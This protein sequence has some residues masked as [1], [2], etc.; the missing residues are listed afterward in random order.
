MWLK[1]DGAARVL[2]PHRLV[3]PLPFLLH[4]VSIQ[5][6]RVDVKLSYCACTALPQSSSLSTIHDYELVLALKLLNSF[7][8]EMSL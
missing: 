7:F 2:H 5:I 6:S 3:G 4:D 1:V 8:H